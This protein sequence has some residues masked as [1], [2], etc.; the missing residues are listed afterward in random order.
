MALTPYQQQLHDRV[1]AAEVIPPPEPWRQVGRGI[2]PVG[3]L[4]GI[5]F[6]VHPETGHD[7]VLT[8]SNSGHGLFDAVTGEKLERDY[9]PEDDPDGPDLSCPGLGPVAD[10]RIPVAG[11]WGGGLHSGAAGGWGV[12]VISPE[13]PSHRVLL[14]HGEGPERNGQHGETWWHVFHSSWSTFRAAGFSPTGRTLAVAT[15]SDLTLWTRH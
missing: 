8:V 15:S 5:G 14:V 4:L 11:L 12:E 3:G 6:A 13:W 10:V 2:V 9:D 7:L 1:V